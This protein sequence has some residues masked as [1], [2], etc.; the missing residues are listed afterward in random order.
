MNI[1]HL[2]HEF[3]C[4]ITQL[5]FAEILWKYVFIIGNFTESKFCAMS[6]HIS[7]F[8]NLC[9]IFCSLCRICLRKYVVIRVMLN[10][11]CVKKLLQNCENIFR[12]ISVVCKRCHVMINVSNC[13]GI[14][15]N[16][17]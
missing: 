3:N 8:H 13:L 14:L 1:V 12:A 7:I 2:V 4:N 10:A 17:Y 16:S 11:V 15:C 9:T 5:Y 6:S